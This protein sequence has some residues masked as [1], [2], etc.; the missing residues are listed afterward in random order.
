[1]RM[2]P[3]VVALAAT[4]LFGPAARATAE[5]LAAGPEHALVITSDGRVLSWGRATSGR[6]GNGAV[7]GLFPPTAVATLAD[8]VAVAAGRA[9]SVALRR[10][11][12]V[13]T[14]GD[15]SRG[16]LGTGG[17]D[18]ATPVQVPGLQGI[19]AI[20]AGDDHT[21]AWSI[22]GPIQAWG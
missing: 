19:A 15:N 1:M 5:P 21:L 9:H 20:A 13:W 3:A 8:V 18:T 10:D 16:Q 22:G 2:R 17:D 12:T 4:L 14:W 6:L 7:A 11:G